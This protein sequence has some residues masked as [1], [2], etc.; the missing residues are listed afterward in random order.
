MRIYN[1]NGKAILVRPSKLIENMNSNET[2][3]K[4]TKK[5]KAKSSES[6]RWGYI[7][8]IFRED[9]LKETEG[10][11]RNEAVVY[12][13]SKFKEERGKEISTQFANRLNGFRL[14]KIGDEF[15]FEN[16]TMTVAEFVKHPI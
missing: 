2:D 15:T 11:T 9:I 13:I 14:V 5:R 3:N 4:P 12:C 10:K 1:T 16:S 7:N 6:D 8:F